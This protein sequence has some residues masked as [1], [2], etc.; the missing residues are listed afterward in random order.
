MKKNAGLQL[1]FL[2]N[3]VTFTGININ[4]NPV[5]KSTRYIVVGLIQQN[6]N[7]ENAGH[8][9]VQEFL[10]GLPHE[11]R[12][13]SADAR[14][15]NQK[16]QK[17]LGGVA[18]L[19]LAALIGGTVLGVHAHRSDKDDIRAKDIYLYNS[20]G[21]LRVMLKGSSGSLTLYDSKGKHTV[22]LSGT[23]GRIGRKKE[24]KIR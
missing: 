7:K 16:P 8:E 17:M 18:T 6:G 2:D 10:G 21:K 15:A 14:K 3:I 1:L 11:S 23:N 22:M 20:S 9:K 4:S 19:A 24:Y 13:K 5:P 12:L